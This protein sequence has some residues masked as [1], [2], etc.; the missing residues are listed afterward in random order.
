MKRS[1]MLLAAVA[2]GAVLSAAAVPTALAMTG[3]KT[4]TVTTQAK[5]GG[6]NPG[7]GAQC[8]YPSNR[9]PAITLKANPTS[10]TRAGNV[11]FSGNLSSNKCPIANTQ[12]GLY[13]KSSTG[14]FSRVATALTDAAGNYK[15]APVRVNAGTTT[16]GSANVGDQNYDFTYSNLI[17]FSNV[18]P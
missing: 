7:N 6:G 16:F 11:D 13:S 5:P 15:F 8:G 4:Q 1:K 12:V 3:A 10:L 14:N 2:S 17:T 9:T 18:K